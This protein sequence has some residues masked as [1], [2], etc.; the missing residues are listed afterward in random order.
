MLQTS[1]TRPWELGRLLHERE[2]VARMF[3]GML[4]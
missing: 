2:D 4:R 3:L 1:R